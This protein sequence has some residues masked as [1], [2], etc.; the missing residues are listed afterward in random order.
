MR[1]LL[2]AIV[3]LLLAS[4]AMAQDPYW[5]NPEVYAENKLPAR[6]TLTPYLSAGEALRRG[7]SPLVMDI[8][9][10]W[11]F[12]WSATPDAAPEGFEAVD[13][14]DSQ[15]GSIPVPG[16][17]EI[18]G[19]GVPIYTN[20]NYPHPMNPPYIPHTDNPTGCYR[21][22]F[23]LPEAWSGRR[24]ILHFESGLAAMHIWVNGSKVGYS[25]GTKTAVEFDITE[26]LK[27][28]KNLLAINRLGNTNKCSFPRAATA[29]YRKAILKRICV[30]LLYFAFL[31]V[32]KKLII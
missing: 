21:Y 25:E 27:Q 15:W 4:V 14:D 1:R 22:E 13:Y 2:I 28:G 23:T 11:K 8:S 24:T 6:A 17:W 16:N 30:P 19:Y 7:D 12:A 3:A 31:I 32:F 29:L 10:D 5:E 26:Y 20:V 18:N 9:G